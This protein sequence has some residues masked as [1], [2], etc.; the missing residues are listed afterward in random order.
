M[1]KYLGH[2]RNVESKLKASEEGRDKLA[3]DYN[4]TLS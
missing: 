4:N 3:K 2:L 1:R